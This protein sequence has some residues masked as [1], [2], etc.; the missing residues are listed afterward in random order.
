MLRAVNLLN[1]GATRDDVRASLLDDGSSEDMAFL[2]Y[3][4]AKWL[5][6]EGSPR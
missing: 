3:V 1:Y 2:A 4:A 6:E 5:L